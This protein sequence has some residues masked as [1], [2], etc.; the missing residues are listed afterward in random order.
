VGRLIFSVGWLNELFTSV[1]NATADLLLLGAWSIALESIAGEQIPV[2][3][4]VGC[5]VSNSLAL[6][7]FFLVLL[8]CTR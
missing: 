5:S 8:F 6:L 3:N 2:S 7:L 4:R 1:A